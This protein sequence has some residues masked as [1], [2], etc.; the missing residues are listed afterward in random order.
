MLDCK[1]QHREVMAA[2]WPSPEGTKTDQSLHI[3]RRQCCVA[4]MCTDQEPK[5][6]SSKVYR[7]VSRLHCTMP[8]EWD[9][10]ILLE[11]ILLPVSAHCWAEVKGRLRKCLCSSQI[12]VVRWK[13]A[14][15]SWADQTVHDPHQFLQLSQVPLTLGDTFVVVLMKGEIT[16]EESHSTSN[17]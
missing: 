15:H 7:K 5:L 13:Q 1:L 14:E 8:W 3:W 11:M 17:T 10:D 9:G 4:C 12:S 16:V 2:S 6:K